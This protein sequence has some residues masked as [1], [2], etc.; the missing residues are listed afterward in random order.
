MNV[1]TRLS[2]CSPGLLGLACV[3]ALLLSSRADAWIGPRVERIRYVE[4]GGFAG[5][6]QLDLRIYS[7]GDAV[8]RKGFSEMEQP[9]TLRLGPMEMNGLLALFAR[10]GFLRLP[11]RLPSFSPV[12]DG[13]Q[14]ALTLRSPMPGNPVG[15]PYTVSSATGAR[16]P[17]G[18]RSLRERLGALARRVAES[19]SSGAPGLKAQLTARQ[20][21]DK[22]LLAFTIR[23]LSSRVELISQRRL[24]YW[25]ELEAWVEGRRVWSSSEGKFW[26][27]VVGAPRPLSPGGVLTLRDEFPILTHLRGGGLYATVTFGGYSFGPRVA[28]RKVLQVSLPLRGAGSG[29]GP[30]PGSGPSG[31]LDTLNGR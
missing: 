4:S 8:L 23:N 7:N 9:A 12:M 10:S 22:V 2:R 16:E 11:P 15:F 27:A 6:T 26:P 17:F 14:Y 1:R 25:A 3:G 18:Y 24:G 30:G 20:V 19:G 31:I 28:A 21:G 13:L 29:S 5:G